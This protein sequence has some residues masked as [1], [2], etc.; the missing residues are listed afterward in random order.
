MSITDVDK[1][2]IPAGTL[3][4]GKGWYKEAMVNRFCHSR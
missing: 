2:V 3:Y 1:V 4:D